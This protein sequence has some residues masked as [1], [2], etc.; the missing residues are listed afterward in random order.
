MALTQEQFEQLPDFV[1]SDY[2]EQDGGF[3]HA[4]SVKVSK[5]KSSLDGLDSKLR[6]FERKEAEKL[7]E[8]ER[9]ALEKLKKEGKVD[10]IVA[11]A[12][13]RIGE[14]AKQYQD[15]IDRLS[16]QIKTEKRSAL[17][18]DLSA[19]LATDIGSAAFK[20]LVSSR[21]DVDP[22]TG[23]VTF[24]NA[25]GSAS[26]LDFAGFKAEL[27][28]DSTFAPLIKASIAASGG[29]LV[30]GAQHGG[31]TSFGAGDFGGDKAQRQA[32]IATKFK[33][34]LS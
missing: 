4:E 31:R 18:A 29:G 16:S 3:V 12:E 11:D 34:P 10:E 17:V 22:E 9:A 24:L 23:K 27:Q 1:K 6:D 25:D 33:L 14:T 5:L 21:I 19:E 2:V 28:K 20:A 13:R 26:S 32:A 8:A 15:R 30:N 7:A